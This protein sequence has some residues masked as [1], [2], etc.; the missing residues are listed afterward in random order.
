MLS[1]RTAAWVVLAL[2]GLVAL[3]QLA[4]ALG[5]PWGAYA[6]GGAFEGTYPPVMRAAALAQI[7]VYAGIAAIVS[8]RA[9]LAFKRLH[10]ASRVLIWIVAALFLAG[11]VL[12]AI[13]P[14][15]GESLVWTPVT[16]VLLAGVL[17]I[18]LARPA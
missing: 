15:R 16:A 18:A 9:N 1:A 10:A 5:A 14:S 8:A 17:R 11:L 13:S 2:L 12:N 7:A 6:M 4:L 3:F